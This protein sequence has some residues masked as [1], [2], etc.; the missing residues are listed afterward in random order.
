[1]EFGEENGAKKGWALYIAVENR[2]RPDETAMP[3]VE[4]LWTILELEGGKKL[5]LI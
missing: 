3:V 1:M 2:G 4:R 5:Y